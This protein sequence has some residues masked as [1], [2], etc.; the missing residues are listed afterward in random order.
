MTT[1]LPILIIGAGPVGL[2]L[3]LALARQRLSVELFEAMPDLSPEIRASTFHPP[4]LEMF[5]EW[6]VVD[7]VLAQGHKVDRLLYWERQSRELIAE[8]CYRHI[9]AD[10]PFP[11]RLQCPQ[12]VLTRTLKPLVEALPNARVHMN[13]RLVGF[14]DC[15]D[16][17]TAELETPNGRIIIQGA[18]LCGADGASSTVRKGLDLGFEGMTY[19]DRFLLIGTDLDLRPHFPAIGPVNYM[20]DPD[21]WVIILYLADVVRVV[22]RLRPEEIEEEA[23]AE[24]AVRQRLH[25]FIGRPVNFNIKSRSVYRVHQRVADTFRQGR[26]LL[27]G[28][29]AH[30]NNPA[31]GMGMNSGI[32]DAYHLARALNQDLTGFQNL[33]GLNQ[34]DSLDHYSQTRRQTALEAIRAY[35]DKNYADLSA[36][37]EAYRRRRNAD[38]RATAADPAQARAYLLRASMMADRI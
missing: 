8:F 24:T 33:S 5:A 20:Y 18:Y 30:I 38:L 31:G 16:H 26:V 19:E 35:S 13:H 27:L 29:A 4:T 9:A 15:G 25:N 36:R 7:K 14:Q 17:V 32:H 11:F 2:S 34:T 37:D 28:D 23:L 3:A 1:P 22:F 6:G 12:S 10:T 21:E